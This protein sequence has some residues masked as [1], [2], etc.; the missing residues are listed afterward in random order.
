MSERFFIEIKN[1]KYSANE[2]NMSDTIN[3]LNELILKNNFDVQFINYYIAECCYVLSNFEFY[4]FGTNEDYKK[5]KKELLEFIKNNSSYFDAKTNFIL[6]Y[7][8][9]VMPNIF[10]FNIDNELE[11]ENKGKKKL[12]EIYFSN[13]DNLIYKFFY[14]GTKN[15]KN[16][17]KKIAKLLCKDI[18]DIFPMDS[19]IEEYFNSIIKNASK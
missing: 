16:V 10:T 11:I 7:F 2:F 12:E 1:I 9:G 13:K 14:Y 3:Y 17:T 19:N 18:N 4:S 15:K 5:I 6:G 8:M